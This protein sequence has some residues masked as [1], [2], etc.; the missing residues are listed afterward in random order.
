MT[1]SVLSLV[2]LMCAPAFSDTN[3]VSSTNTSDAVNMQSQGLTNSGNASQGQ[4]QGIGNSGNSSQ[5][6]SQGIGNS[7][8][9]SQSQGIAN[10]GNAS[11][12]QSQGQG[13]NVGGGGTNTNVKA[14]NGNTGLGS[15]NGASGSLSP[16][17]GVS[18]DQSNHS[19]NSVQ[20]TD[21]SKAV[22]N[23]YAPALTTTL[24]ET[25]M[26]SSSVGAGFAGGS[27]SFGTTWRDSACVRRLDA[28]EI[29]SLGD[30]QVAKEIMCDSDL[31]REAFKRVGRPCS[32][33]GGNYM[34]TSVSTKGKA[35]AYTGA[36]PPPIDNAVPISEQEA[37]TI[38]QRNI[39][40]QKQSDE[41]RQII[42]DKYGF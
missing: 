1:N 8:N 21:L 20:A 3:V 11:Q 15:G 25:C 22:G 10:T 34:V 33:D 27:F 31:V 23:S 2:T 7:G 41:A 14:N 17:A 26:G 40:I 38:R 16:T 6:Q 32:I 5:G 30:V 13:I 37:A 18:L 42:R 19:T 24:T 28:R 35:L 12:G 39:E 29:K 36:P 4:S 9:S